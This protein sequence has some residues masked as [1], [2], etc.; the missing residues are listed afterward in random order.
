MSKR[1]VPS[2]NLNDYLSKDVDVKNKFVKDLYN[3]FKEYGFV[4]FNNHT[5]GH[6]TIDDAYKV[7]R[8]F[9]DLPDAVKRQYHNNKG[10]AR[11]YTPF[12][13]EQ[14]KGSPAKDLK[15]FWHVGRELDKSHPDYDPEYPN[16]WPAELSEFKSTF[17]DIYS[18]LDEMGMVI[19]QALGE[20]LDVKPD[21]FEKIA[22]NG[23]SI[24]RLLHYP[25]VPEG[26]DPR[27][28]RAG[29]HS[30]INLITL[31]IASNQ[32]GLELLDRD[33][34]WLPVECN[35]NSIVVN[36]GD[37]LSRIC[38]DD[39]PSTIHRVVNPGAEHNV[40]RLSMPFFLHPRPEAML[41]CLP[42]FIGTGAKYPDIKADDF[43]QERLKEIGLKK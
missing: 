26:V 18:K 11:G 23:N 8:A 19:L 20:S 15:E 38:N 41:S 27:C 2:L 29:A 21:F 25:P 6:G 17:M 5:L 10:G 16:F 24:L 14:A 28:V 1:K 22:R 37:M 12:G 33:G 7:Q 42:K 32:S 9:F 30:D 36:M 43:L 40:S 4:V 13:T 31:L 35:Q 3:A 34:Q 39:V